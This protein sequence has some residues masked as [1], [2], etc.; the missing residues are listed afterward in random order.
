MLIHSYVVMCFVLFFK[1][2]MNHNLTYLI[3]HLNQ[4]D[5]QDPDQD[6]EQQKGLTS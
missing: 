2:C 6:G 4:E 5:F 1:F 3:F